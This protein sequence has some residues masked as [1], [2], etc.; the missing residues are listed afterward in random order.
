MIK[1]E[2]TRDHIDIPEAEEE[3]RHPSS[4]EMIN[5][6]ALI[7]KNETEISEL[8]VNYSQ[9]LENRR[10]LIEHQ[11]VLQRAELFFSEDTVALMSDGDEDNRQL[12][13]IA[14]V[15]DQERF[16]S[17]ERMLWRVSHGNIFVKQAR[18]EEVL[19]DSMS[20]SKIVRFFKEI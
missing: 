5:L 20:V 14:G 11:S 19:Q 3:P 2:L 9:L 10:F 4:R 1:R 18:V 15:V 7:E 13:F 12:Q 17:F 8:A 16:Y 6:E